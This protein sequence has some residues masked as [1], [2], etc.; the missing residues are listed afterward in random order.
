MINENG[1]FVDKTKTIAPQLLQAGL[2]TGATFSDYDNDG[3]KDL[4]VSA[5]W[6]SIKFYENNNG[7]F[8]GKQHT[9]EAKSLMSES[10]KGIGKGE[11]NSQY[12]TCW[13]TR[14]GVVVRSYEV[15][16]IRS[17][18]GAIQCCYDVSVIAPLILDI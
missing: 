7:N 4:I 1:T 12:G 6:S 14:D 9:E 8:S 17:W 16:G 3:D 10:K 2:V 11:T 15:N 18:V 5:E 13:I